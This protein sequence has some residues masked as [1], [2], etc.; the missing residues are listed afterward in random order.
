MIDDDDDRG[1]NGANPARRYSQVDDG[2]NEYKRLILSELERISD[3]LS[4]IDEKMDNKI[5]NEVAKLQVEIA[6][7]KV[8]S[9]IWGALAGVI[10]AISILL[11][12]F[13]TSGK[14][15]IH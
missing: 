5:I 10:A 12:S 2:W 8:K 1:A 11:L 9:G 3:S 13:L 14:I 6:M 4:D 15:S 7:L